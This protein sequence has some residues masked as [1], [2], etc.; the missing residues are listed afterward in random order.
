MKILSYRFKLSYRKV[1]F[2]CSVFISYQSSVLALF[3]GEIT[4]FYRFKVR[5]TLLW[6][7]WLWCFKTYWLSMSRQSQVLPW[8][9]KLA[10]RFFMVLF[11]HY[12]LSIID[13]IFLESRKCSRESLFVS[14]EHYISADYRI[15]SI[16]YLSLHDSFDQCFLVCNLVCLLLLSLF[17]CQLHD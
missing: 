8:K 6:C 7:F 12:Q 2:W 14:Y 3:V 16:S 9:W 13:P 10:R 15:L 11:Y 17:F 4:K 5:V 1:F